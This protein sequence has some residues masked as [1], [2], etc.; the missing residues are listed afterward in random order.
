[1]FFLGLALLFGLRFLPATHPQAEAR[2]APP[3]PEVHG[4]PREAQGAAAPTP[5]PTSPSFTTPRDSFDDC[6]RALANHE[7]SVRSYLQRVKGVGPDDA[8]DIVRESLLAVCE[9][10][11]ALPYAS[12]GSVLQR[13]AERRAISR[14]RHSRLECFLSE[15][16]PS[17]SASPDESA[18]FAQ[19]VRAVDAALCQE[20]SDAREIVRRRV[21]EEEDF[22][23]I[24]KDFGL[25]AD[26]A[27]TVFHNALRRVQKRVR[28]ACGS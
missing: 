27:R 23:A 7:P 17:C 2:A 19:E 26:G 12:L 25:S 11:G 3:L 9:R 21:V 20:T 15:D 6:L 18:R 13:A 16:V 5:A 10:H 4:P 8:H 22:D 14:W 28:E 24:G 1:M